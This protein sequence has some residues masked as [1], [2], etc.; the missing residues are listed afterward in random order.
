[1]NGNT[2]GRVFRVTTCGES[3][4]G[5]FR[6]ELDIPSCL[7]GGLMT[8]VDG[9][10]AGIKLTADMIQEELNKRKPGQSPLD[11][12]RLEKDLVYI[13]SGVMMDQMTTGAPVGIVI[14][15]NDIENLHIGQYHDYQEA[16]RPGHAEI[17]YMKRYGQYNDWVGAG[18]AS[19]RETVSRVAGGA[20]AKAI[21]DR[22][23]IDVIAY[24][25]E[26]HGIKAKPITYEEAKAN[27][28]KNDINCPDLAVAPA[29]EKDI[30]DVRKTGETCGGIIE[31]LVHGLPVG[32]GEP[33]FDKL[34]AT[35]AHGL[36]SIGAV[37]GIE[38]GAGFKV[39]EMVGSECNDEMYWDEETGR[40]RYYSNNAGGFL[41]GLSNGDEVR[42]RIAVKPTP[43]V[44]V[45]Q[46]TVDCG[47][48]KNVELSPITRR[49]A[50]LLPR[51]YPVCEAMVRI[52]IV[53]ALMQFKGY[54]NMEDL[55]PK[56]DQI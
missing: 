2:F 46:R 43:T 33:C 11:S 23:G 25:I 31:L 13:F 50:S 30:L 12:P 26:S 5:G 53:D 18:R 17:T 41:G 32:L 16:A 52:A 45:V 3:Y 42:I 35:I 6:K 48:H 14:P 29:M 51:I 20:V 49:D 4:S 36:M 22:E 54:R 9:V 40:V 15:N 24:T 21:L 39:A 56:Y 38:V 10:P 44:D 19:G 37:K 7:Y 47:S 27:Y 28:R 55:D 1:M 34:E 8:I